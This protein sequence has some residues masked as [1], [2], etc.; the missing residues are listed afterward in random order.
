MPPFHA[1]GGA[2]AVSARNGRPVRQLF[3]AVESVNDI[4][5]NNLS[6]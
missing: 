2:A 4:E 6:L 1:P 3:H 5:R